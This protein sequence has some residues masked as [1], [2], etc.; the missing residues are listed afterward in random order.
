ME[1]Q[2]RNARLAALLSSG[3]LG[4]AAFSAGFI[5]TVGC[6]NRCIEVAVVQGF[7]IASFAIIPLG[8]AVLA[9]RTVASLRMGR[10][11]PPRLWMIIL[12]WCF[13]GFS[14]I[15]A[16]WAFL[17]LLVSPYLHGPNV[18]I[19]FL[20][21]ALCWSAAALLS[22]VAARQLAR[23]RTRSGPIKTAAP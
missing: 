7:L 15:V 6:K 17:Y 20:I 13:A 21:F 22:A 14:G 2:A 9:H 10:P 23:I 3:A 8:H 1:I 16:G 4:I 12:T 18:A 19:A 5:S 11:L